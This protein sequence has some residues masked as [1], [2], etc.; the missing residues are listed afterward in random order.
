MSAMFV[1]RNRVLHKFID[2]TKVNVI[3]FGQLDRK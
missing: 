2:V 1:T 3:T